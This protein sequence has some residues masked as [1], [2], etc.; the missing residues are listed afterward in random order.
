MMNH[1]E[2]EDLARS[3]KDVEREV[4]SQQLKELSSEALVKLLA[5]KWRSVGDYAWS[6]LYSHRIGEKTLILQLICDGFDNGL[7]RIVDA[8]VRALN[9]LVANAARDDRAKEIYRRYLNDRSSDV[10]SC[11]LPG[12]VWSL[13]EEALPILREK[14]QVTSNSYMLQA[15]REAV[16]AI[17]QKNPEIMQ[18]AKRDPK[19]WGVDLE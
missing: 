13:D 17:S 10:A 9:F 19:Q 18:G 12:A 16:S 14:I 2:I 1:K 8:R 15:F 4:R 6:V 11:A 5:V 3:L 7:F